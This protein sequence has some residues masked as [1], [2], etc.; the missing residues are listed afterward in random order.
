V[1]KAQIMTIQSQ[2]KRT[3]SLGFAIFGNCFNHCRMSSVFVEPESEIKH[4]VPVE[5]SHYS[6]VL[7][8]LPWNSMA[9]GTKV[10]VAHTQHPI[11][12][13]SFLAAD[14]AFA[15]SQLPLCKT[16]FVLRLGSI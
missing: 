1:G 3:S 5:T 10:P 8:I 14:K 4:W 7:K 6:S 16:T 2:Y 11:V 15:L 13:A 12:T 9:Y